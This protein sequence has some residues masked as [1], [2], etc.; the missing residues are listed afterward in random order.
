MEITNETELCLYEV[1][2]MEDDSTLQVVAIDF[3]DLYKDLIEN[4]IEPLE[5][6]LIWEV[7]VT[8]RVLWK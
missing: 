1:K 2:R 5:I 4:N 7:N 6:K 8:N 3:N